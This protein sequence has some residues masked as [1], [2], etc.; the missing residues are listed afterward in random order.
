MTKQISMN[1]SFPDNEKELYR[2]CIRASNS[3]YTPSSML[4]RGFIREGLKNLP[5]R[6]KLMCGGLKSA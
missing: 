5:E 1:I 6:A 2:D 3:T 4:V